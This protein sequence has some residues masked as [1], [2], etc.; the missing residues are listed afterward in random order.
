MDLSVPE[1]SPRGT[2]RGNSKVDLLLPQASRPR[3]EAFPPT[4]HYLEVIPW[5]ILVDDVDVGVEAVPFQSFLRRSVSD[6]V[7]VGDDSAGMC[8]NLSELP[9]F[10]ADDAAAHWLTYIGAFEVCS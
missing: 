8:G 1:T 7:F 6:Q 9:T 2:V 5:D 3:R 10:T 4:S